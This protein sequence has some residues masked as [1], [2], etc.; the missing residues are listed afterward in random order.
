MLLLCDAAA[1]LG[2]SS[3]APS[4]VLGAA[5]LLQNLVL[6]LDSV[7][8][9][10]W[11]LKAASS[12]SS[13]P[14]LRE[15]DEMLLPSTLTGGVWSV[16]VLGHVRVSS[17]FFAVSVV[18]GVPRPLYYRTMRFS[19]I[20][21]LLCHSRHSWPG[22]LLWHGMFPALAACSLGQVA[23]HQLDNAL[24]AYPIDLFPSWPVH[25]GFDRGSSRI[26]CWTPPARGR[27]RAPRLEPT[28]CRPRRTCRRMWEAFDGLNNFLEHTVGAST[29]LSLGLSRLSLLSVFFLHFQVPVSR[30]LACL[31]A[32]ARNRAQ[33]KMNKT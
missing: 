22:C 25:L 33:T 30:L 23:E 10:W 14:H 17:F 15:G 24:G 19:R 32:K 6:E 16:Y 4:G 18:G 29:L 9:P 31:V 12:F 1:Q 21:L 27:E 8:L 3:V 2:R 28:G 7:V 20:C 26:M 11:I 13:P 5:L